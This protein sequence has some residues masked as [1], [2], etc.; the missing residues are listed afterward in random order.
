MP[1]SPIDSEGDLL[2]RLLNPNQILYAQLLQPSLRRSPS[3]ERLAWLRQPPKFWNPSLDIFRIAIVVES[4][5][6]RI[7]LSPITRIIT[8]ASEVLP[9]APIARKVI[10][11]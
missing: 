11:H 2:E 8:D 1:S 4:L 10:V 6:N 7:E 3:L 9:I 5:L